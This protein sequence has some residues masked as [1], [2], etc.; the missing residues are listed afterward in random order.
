MIS[1]TVSGVFD[2]F[3]AFENHWIDER[4]EGLARSP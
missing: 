4:G 2:I 3:I 1:A